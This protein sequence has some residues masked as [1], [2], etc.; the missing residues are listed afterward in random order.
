MVQQYD[1][2]PS[3]TFDMMIWHSRWN[4][5]EVDKVIPKP[6]ARVTIMRN[7]VDTFESGYVYLGYEKASGL[8]INE[9]AQKLVE[10]NFR[11]RIKGCK[12]IFLL[13][14]ILM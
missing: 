14:C 1:W 2:N 4:R 3:K 5:E 8:N 6:S 13:L 10:Q 12:L 11:G 9:F 7:P